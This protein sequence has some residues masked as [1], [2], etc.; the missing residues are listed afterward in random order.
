MNDNSKIEFEELVNQVKLLDTRMTNQIIDA[1]KIENV[2]HAVGYASNPN[3]DEI[4]K[5]Y[6]YQQFKLN[7]TQVQDYINM[8]S[9][10]TFETIKGMKE[11]SQIDL[12][13][14]IAKNKGNIDFLN[15][16][17]KNIYDD[18]EG[19]LNEDCILIEK[20][21]K[22]YCM[23][24]LFLYRVDDLRKLLDVANTKIEGNEER[25]EEAEKEIENLKIMNSELQKQLM[26]QQFQQPQ[27]INQMSTPQ[28]SINEN[29]N[30][31]K[32]GNQ[33][34]YPPIQSPMN[35]TNN[36]NNMNFNSMNDNEFPSMTLDESKM[37]KT[38]AIAMKY[39]D[40]I[41][42]LSS[43]R[44]GATIIDSKKNNT[45]QDLFL[46]IRGCTNFVLLF[47]LN[48]GETFGSFHSVAPETYEQSV[49]DPNHFLFSISNGYGE[50][51]KRYDL[52][53]GNVEV[54][55]FTDNEIYI[56]KVGVFSSLRNGYMY[57]E[58]I[59]LSMYYHNSPICGKKLFSPTIQ[60]KRFTW[61]D[62][63]LVRLE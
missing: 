59:P 20:S 1:E 22:K 28:F 43:F 29:Y 48:T 19:K 4:I 63:I 2:Y 10:Y 9:N 21:L 45:F 27:A 32:S 16:I 53:D 12:C 61:R 26:N 8:Y 35:Q 34:Q 47:F 58:S 62:I 5:N 7:E 11:R 25:I 24:E 30:Q 56:S 36:M 33:I 42:Q 15:K 38:N 3:A 60:P 50:K 40:K 13:I 17:M 52:K 46:A 14:M 39:M 55:K 44:S 41:C 31:I 54:L 6:L 37:E 49:K 23:N 57:S 18:E 51:M